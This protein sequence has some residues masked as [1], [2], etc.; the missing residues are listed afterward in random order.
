MGGLSAQPPANREASGGLRSA[1]ARARLPSGP[2][3]LGPTACYSAARLLARRRRRRPPG[4]TREPRIHSAHHCHEHHDGQHKHK[5]ARGGAFEGRALPSS[6]LH[7]SWRRKRRRGRGRRP[8]AAPLPAQW[9]R[10]RRRRPVPLATQ[11]PERHAEY[12]CALRVLR[13][14]HGD[15]RLPPLRRYT[16]AA[17]R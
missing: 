9:A 5:L 2:V 6:W 8:Q 7:W 13:Q 3:R 11:S 14:Q 17:R 4:G 1:P 12:P 10:A 16:L 15:R